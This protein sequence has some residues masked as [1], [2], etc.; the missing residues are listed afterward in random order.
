MTRALALPIPSA[1][2]NLDAF[3]SKFNATGSALLYS[4][5][6]G[7]AADDFANALAVDSAGNVYV[8]GDTRS[9]DFNT[10]NPLQAANRGGLDAFVTKLNANGSD[11]AYSTYLGGAGEDL[12]LSVALDTAGNAYITGYT[13]SN[14]F[15]TRNPLQATSR[16]GLEVF[17][18]KLLTDSND[19][20]FNTYFGGNGADT[21]NAIAVDG[22]GN[23]Y[24]TGATT[25]TNLPTRFPLQ[26][27]S[28]GGLDAFVAKFNATGSNL[29]YAT[30][31]GGNQADQ[32]RGIA[33]DAAGNAFVAGNTFSSNFPTQSSLQSQPR[34]AGDAFIT[35]LNATGSAL[36]YSTYF[37]GSAT[38]GANAIAL[39]ASGAA[40][41]AGDTFS[42]DL[43]TRN[44]LQANT[45]GQQD[46][47]VAKLTPDGVQLAY[48]TYLGGR[49]DDLANG[50]AVDANGNAY[51]TGNTFSTDFRTVEAFQSSNRGESD[52]FVSK[53]VALAVPKHMGMN[54]KFNACQFA[55]TR[56]YLV[57]STCSE[58]SFS[59]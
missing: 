13:S 14:D 4:T 49:R 29:I 18:T 19:V 39:D 56:N 46:A 31:L 25:S 34:G 54:P 58:W 45:R 26:L 16:G 12:G 55:G 42:N 47:F 57:N 22:G 20:A 15:V 27:N 6:L 53:L 3:V 1:V 24:I 37:G 32:A 30:Y 28:G 11:L 10:R 23:A 48:A 52:A 17:V 35:K 44:P 21:G 51:V 2:G 38:D 59:L 33:V 7:G 40:Y 43:P 36:L 5:Y 50:I 9:T 41:V 8:T